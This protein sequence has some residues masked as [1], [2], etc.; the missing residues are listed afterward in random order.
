[1]PAAAPPFR[2]SPSTI[3]RYFFHDCERF[4]Y[5]TAATPRERQRQDIPKPAFDHSPLV[6]SILASGYQWEREVVANLLKDKVVIAPGPGELH[7]RRLSLIQTLR[8]LRREPAGRFLYQPTLVPP[9]EFYTAHGIDRNWVVINENHPDLIAVLPGADGRR[10]LRVVDLKRGEAL[11]LTHRVQVLFYALE[12][13][14]M[15]DAEGIDAHVDLEQGAVWLGKQAEPQ[16]FPLG[17]FRPHLERFLR[18]D[19]VR[20][21]AGAAREAHWHLYDRCEWCEFFASCRDEM[22][23]TNDVSRLVQLTPYGKRHLRE[24]AGVQ[25]LTE[26]GKFL[27]RGDADEVLNRCASLAGQRHRLAVRVAALESEEP[28]LH[29]AASPDLPRG[30]NLAVFLTLQKEPLGQTIYLA[31]LHVTGRDDVRRAVFS[32]QTARQLADDEGKPQPWIALARRPDEAANVRREF[33]VLLDDLFHR[34]HRYNEQHADWKNKLTLQAYVHTEDERA[35][36]FAAL[37]EALQEADLA[38]KA[39]TLLF[40]FQG[41]ELMQAN[42]HPGTEVAYPVVVLQNAI[43]RLLAL[44]VEVSYTLPEVLEALGSPFRYTRRDY[45]HF[46]LGH[47]LRAEALHA[48]WY[49]GRSANIEEIL[50]QARLYLFAVAALLRAVRE[51]AEQHLFAWSPR[52][53]LPTG[54]GIREPML[55]RLAFFARYESLLR[56]LA[57]REAR[58]EA[59]ATQVLLGQ[60]IQV[61]A[62]DA[63][64]MEVIGN[65]VVE[66]ETSGFPAWLLV[67]DND[68]GRRAQVEY[69]DY[70][71]RN[72]VHGGPDS[73]HRAI[74]GVV[75]VH[76]TDGGAVYLRLEYARKF[77]D[78]IP[79]AGERF[80]LYQR[81]T[82]FTTDPLVRFLEE[83]DQTPDGCALFLQLLRRTEEA[84]T[85]LP[86]PA[87]VRTTAVGLADRLNFTPSQRQAYQTICSQRVAAVWGPPGTGKTHFLAATIVALA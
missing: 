25:T 82:D 53:A 14:A 73:P 87:K 57:I 35:L 1:M 28:Q 24:E 37:L 3:A 76:T 60:V 66:P 4:L 45:Y 31:G 10:L 69:V 65:L 34:V 63:G 38:E 51:R 40:H 84:A 80:L 2:I 62:I 79:R 50:Q 6:E 17:D 64:E 61:K 47:G 41:P 86:L 33:V 85:P 11:K 68:D 78:R 46:P 19:L 27:Q 52:F 55:S 9:P 32:P 26:L 21:L 30:E 48:A 67:R 54:A 42:R 36:L 72:K 81:F 5:Y 44:P 7:T 71:Y 75:A 70:W 83:L 29:G 74:V 49:S 12:L 18:H 22:R 8:H 13:Q 58:A 16:L 43:G 15:L 77:K 56:C 59:R 23:R 39:M 20:I